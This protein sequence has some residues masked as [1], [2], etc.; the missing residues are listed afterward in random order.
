MGGIADE[1][2]RLE[3]KALAIR[4]Y[5]NAGDAARLEELSAE[6]TAAGKLTYY[7]HDA[8]AAAAVNSGAW[9]LALRHAE[10]ALGMAPPEIVRAD[11]EAGGRQVEDRIVMRTSA[12]RYGNSLAVKGWALVNLG[13]QEEGYAVFE[14]GEG[15]ALNFYIGVPDS[16]LN[17]YWAKALLQA[18]DSTSA[19]DRIAPDAVWLGRDEPIELLKEAFI[20]SGGSADGF[21]DF[22][23]ARRLELAPQVDDFTLPDYEGNEHTFS[24]LMGKVTVLSFW[25]P[26]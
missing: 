13:R 21:E 9:E 3:A 7:N 26:T 23:W 6:L 19:M 15:K 5:G 22:L 11:L 16:K 14:E 20:A 4:V 8:F 2:R 17:L 24:D 18:G 25:F 12:W 1:E 10:A